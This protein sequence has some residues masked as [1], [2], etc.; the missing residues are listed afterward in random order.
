LVTKIDN[1]ATELLKNI[2]SSGE[3]AAQVAL[4]KF[5]SEYFHYRSFID[6]G[7]FVDNLKRKLGTNTNFTLIYNAADNVSTALSAAVYLHDHYSGSWP[8][9]PHETGLSI[10]LPDSRLNSTHALLP[11]YSA[12]AMCQDTQWDEMASAY[13][14]TT[15][16]PNITQIHIAPE[17]IT[18]QTDIDVYFEVEKS[19]VPINSTFILYKD[20]VLPHSVIPVLLN[21]SGDMEWYKGTIP[22]IPKGGG[23][24]L[25]I[26]C[27]ATNALGYTAQ[28]IHR[29]YIL[30]TEFHPRIEI[31]VVSPVNITEYT[32]ATVTF[33][34]RGNASIVRA[35][36]IYRDFIRWH[37]ISAS[38]ING[39][40]LEGWWSAIIPAISGGRGH[41]LRI[42]AQATD[43]ADRTG[44]GFTILK[45]IGGMSIPAP[46]FTIELFLLVIPGLLLLT[47]ARKKRKKCKN[48]Y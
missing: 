38:Q 2:S 23:R 21:Q 9:H 26:T 48:Q 43:Q 8:Y 7:H 39:T 46:G 12:V 25:E 15:K 14:N 40:D 11:D 3:L 41:V 24:D 6:L 28:V 4:A 16:T 5:A 13:I 30:M 42:Q 31:T 32:E 19:E 17:V 47:W 10:Y 22:A 29:T 44:R 18:P 35:R 1:L 36:V 20:Y 45:I 33:H 27:V 37:S 34:V